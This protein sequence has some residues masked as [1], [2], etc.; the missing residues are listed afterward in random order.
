MIYNYLFSVFCKKCQTL[1]LWVNQNEEHIATNKF[2]NHLLS[3]KT[4]RQKMI[5]SNSHPTYNE[6]QQKIID[7]IDWTLDKY[8]AVTNIQKMNEQV[9]I[10]NV[11]EELDKKRDIA[12]KQKGKSCTKG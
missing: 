5:H 6:R 2:E 3:I 9:I 11:I 8:T 10:D 12:I 7:M 4:E 1:T